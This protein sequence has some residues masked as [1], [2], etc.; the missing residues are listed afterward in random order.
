VEEIFIA[1]VDGLPGFKEAI[2]TIYPDTKVQRYIVHQIRN[3]LKFLNYKERK[4]FAQELKDVYRAHDAEAGF[5]SLERLNKEYPEFSPALK[6]WYDNSNELSYF[7]E[8]PQ[9]I[10]KIIYTT[11]TIESINSQ[12]KKVSRSK[13]VFPTDDSL[14]KV[15]YLASKNMLKKWTQKIRGWEKILRMLVVVYPEKMDK[16]LI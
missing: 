5:S 8:Y 10:R 11:N 12:F 13:A 15:L 6:S 2:N 4:L 7:F 9:E 1:S 14:Q 3:T 16:Y